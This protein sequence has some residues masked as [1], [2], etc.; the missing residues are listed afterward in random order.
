[1]L[2]SKPVESRLGALRSIVAAELISAFPP[3][4]A[5]MSWNGGTPDPDGPAAISRWAVALA[6]CR[7]QSCIGP[8]VT[9][10]VRRDLFSV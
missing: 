7:A 8:P 6:G 5:R 1:M 4:R 9:R 2:S 3:Y 10:Q